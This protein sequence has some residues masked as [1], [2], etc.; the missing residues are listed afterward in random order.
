MKKLMIAVACAGI[1]SGCVA[2]GMREAWRGFKG[3][4]TKILLDTRP[5]A[6]TREFSCA[7]ND[8]GKK[9]EDSLKDMNA[10]VYAR[11]GELTAVYVS[12]NDTTPVGIFVSD[13][14]AEKTK[15][16]VSSPSSFARDALSQKLFSSLDSKLKAKKIEVQLDAVEGG[17]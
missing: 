9:I 6:V 5:D 4:S 13:T 11:E 15:I 14:G 3:D 7:H 16:E 17:H 10:Y 2:G 12:V 8:C 1:V